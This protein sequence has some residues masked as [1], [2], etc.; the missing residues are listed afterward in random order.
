MA[1]FR[2]CAV[3][4]SRASEQKL[5]AAVAAAP[6]QWEQ[7]RLRTEH[8][9]SPLHCHGELYGSRLQAAVPAAPPWQER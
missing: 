3:N 9:L 8:P 5:R 7:Q 6:A 4:L 1:V 2:T